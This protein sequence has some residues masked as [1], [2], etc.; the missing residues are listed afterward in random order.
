MEEIRI[1]LEDEMMFS[2]SLQFLE[3]KIL[4]QYMPKICSYDQWLREMVQ[5]EASTQGWSN[6]ISKSESVLQRVEII[7]NNSLLK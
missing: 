4:T 6:S 5:Y 3:R 7:R 1:C 2:S